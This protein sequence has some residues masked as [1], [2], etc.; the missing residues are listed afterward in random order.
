[1][2]KGQN[3]LI[4]SLLP[5]SK[6]NPDLFLI[7]KLGVQSIAGIFT[8]LSDLRESVLNMIYSISYGLIHFVIAATLSTIEIQPGFMPDTL[9]VLPICQIN[10]F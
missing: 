4:G 7:K 3:K 5:F 10:L 2:K 1:M 8:W 6:V 9:P